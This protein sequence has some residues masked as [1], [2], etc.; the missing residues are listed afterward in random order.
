MYMTEEQEKKYPRSISYMKTELLPTALIKKRKKIFDAFVRACENK[1]CAIEA[2]TWGE[3]PRVIIGS[4]SSNR[5]GFN[6]P[7]FFQQ[8]NPAVVISIRRVHPLEYCVDRPALI[9]NQRRLESTLLHE[10]VHF[11]RMKCGL[12]DENFDFP[13]SQE[14]GDQFEFWA[15]GRLQCTREEL[16][17]GASSIF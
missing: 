17:D 12:A 16:D 9:N 11:V 15:Y 6:P 7:T 8:N 13:D 14:P 5:C 10:L 3:D 2:L 4:V 1:T